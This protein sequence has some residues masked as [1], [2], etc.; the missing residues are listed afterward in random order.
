MGDALHVTKSGMTIDPKRI[1]LGD[2][3]MFT[4][5]DVEQTRP[6]EEALASGEIAA[7]TQMMGF[8]SSDGRALV[9]TRTQMA[10]H[11][12]AQGEFDGEAWMIFY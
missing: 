11:H 7:D 6:L 1:K 4:R 12:V 2:G 5:L 3:V 8:G 10:Y 9:L